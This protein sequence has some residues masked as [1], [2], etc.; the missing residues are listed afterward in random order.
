MLW[1]FITR[2][3]PEANP[4]SA[5][6]LDRLVQYAINYYQDFVKPTKR[7]RAPNEAERAALTELRDELAPAAA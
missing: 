7:Y 6:F 1:G 3:V 4:Q 2:Y 5:P